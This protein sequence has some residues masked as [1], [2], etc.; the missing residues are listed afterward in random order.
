MLQPKTYP[1]LIGKAL[2]LEAEPF[3]TLVEDDNPW[4]E[5]LFL[6]ASLG[7]VIGVAHLIGSLLMTASLPSVAAVQ[8]ALLQAWRQFS[9]NWGAGVDLTAV[10]GRIRQVSSTV[11]ALNGYGGGWFHLFTLVTT[12]FALVLQW[13]MVGLIVFGMARALGGRGTLNQ[14]LGATALM[15]A[16]H[17]LSLLTVIPFVSVGNLLLTT[18]SLLIVYRAAEVTHELPWQRAIWVALAPLGFMLLLA[19]VA[20]FLIGAGIGIF[21]GGPS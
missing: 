3:V 17:A 15:V 19:I 12:P 16:P 14:T 1:E 21:L 5:G 9:P 20:S 13:L 4:V 2:V 11:M 18:W 7:F 8:A 6:T 10:E